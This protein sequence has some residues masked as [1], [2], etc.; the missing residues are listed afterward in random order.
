MKGIVMTVLGSDGKKRCFG[1]EPGKEFYADYHDHEWGVPSRDD[2]HL[3]EFLILEGAQAG[4][5]WATVLKKREGYRKAFHHFDPIKVESMTDHGLEDLRENPEIIRN[6][7]KIYSARQNAR[8]FLKIQQEFG[9]FSNYIWQFVNNKPIMNE[10]HS[11]KDVPVTTPESDAL[12][13]DL[14]KRGMT[15]VGSTI[16]YAYMQA[17]G[18]VNDHV[19]ECWCYGQ[20]NC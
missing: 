6:R 16:M 11:F 4:L 5:S 19:H 12:S 15:F 20:T 9:S 1:G 14:K 13:K 2:Q 3:F 8:A 17:V 7:L 10:W 18:L